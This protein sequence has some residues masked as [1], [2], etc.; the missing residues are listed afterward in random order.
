MYD[1]AR[2]P[3]FFVNLS[4]QRI[5]DWS[6]VYFWDNLMMECIKLAL[7][8]DFDFLLSALLHCS[9]IYNNYVVDEI[10]KK[11]KHFRWV[12]CHF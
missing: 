6:R 8:L 2:R 11:S 10:V 5:E 12:E 7:Q 9:R 1:E 3:G 4:H